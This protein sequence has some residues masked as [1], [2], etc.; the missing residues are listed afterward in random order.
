MHKQ[1]LFWE[2]FIMFFIVGALNW[3]ATYFNLYW[4]L[5]EFDSL[6]H[7]LGGIL[8]S[9]FFIWLYFYSELFK[10]QKRDLKQFLKVS[11]VSILFI[12]VLW[13]A[14]ELIIGEARYGG[15]DYAFDTMVDL[16]MDFFGA[17][18]GCF[19]GYLQELK[20]KS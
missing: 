1:T 3:V 17:L 11:L 20:V 5:S 8:V 19:Y 7:F 15:D 13:E 9:L 16:I 6:V 10:P 14:Y 12:G 2:T 18:A 4:S